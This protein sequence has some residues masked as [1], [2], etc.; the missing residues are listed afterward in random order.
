MGCGP[1]SQVVITLDRTNPTFF[2]GETVTGNVQFFVATDEMEVDQ[3]DL[4]LV[5]ELGHYTEH[6][7]VVN[8]KR[9]K[10]TTFYDKPFISIKQV[11]ARPELGE[12]VFKL[13]KGKYAWPFQMQ[14]PDHVPPTIGNP[15]IYP[16]VRYFLQVVIDKP[17]Y[18][19]NTT[20]NRYLTVYPRVDILQ[21]PNCLPSV[22]GNHNWRGIVLKGT[23]N[24]LGFAPGEPIRV[25]M[26]VDNP[27]GALI[28]QITVTMVRNLR[29]GPVSR[30]NTLSSRIVPEMMRRNEP[31]IVQTFDVVLPPP[32][33]VP[34]YQYQGGLEH[35]VE[36]NINYLLKFDVNVEGIFDDFQM[37]APFVVGSPSHS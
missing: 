15:D 11:L 16:H 6:A 24:K 10:S 9:T 19:A 36:I 27:N 2:G 26:E 12:K 13:V 32:P 23:L 4:K 30:A 37:I 5:G 21:S 35:V 3:V 7:T 33:M 8:G 18:K 17:W 28:K 1:S 31:K 22:F 34:S 20:E 14:L 25:T 29:M